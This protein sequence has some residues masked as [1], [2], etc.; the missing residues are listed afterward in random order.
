MSYFWFKLVFIPI[1]D[2]CLTLHKQKPFRKAFISL[3]ELIGTGNC[4]QTKY[5]F[6]K[7]REENWPPISA[8]HMYRLFSDHLIGCVGYSITR[9]SLIY[10]LVGDWQP[11]APFCIVCWRRERA[12]FSPT[13]S[14][15]ACLA[16]RRAFVRENSCNPATT[17]TRMLVFI[18]L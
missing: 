3:D 9:V 13:C 15:E 4:H 12:S 18:A 6:I 1:L 7:C 11:D 8:P 5:S 10:H 2:R 17:P 16:S 14:S